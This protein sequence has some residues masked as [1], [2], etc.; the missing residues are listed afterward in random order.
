MKKA[1]QPYKNG[2]AKEA[3]QAKYFCIHIGQQIELQ[4]FFLFRSSSS[5]L[6]LSYR[7]NNKKTISY[8]YILLKN[9]RNT[10]IYIYFFGFFRFTEK[11]EFLRYQRVQLFFEEW[12]IR[13]FSPK[14]QPCT[15]P[16][17][18]IGTDRFKMCLHTVYT[19]RFCNF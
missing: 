7:R 13:V 2:G 1:L 19:C 3:R 10:T 9:S 16:C 6:R 5:L 18:M 11:E 17:V 8:I 14:K 4:I 15:P 12:P